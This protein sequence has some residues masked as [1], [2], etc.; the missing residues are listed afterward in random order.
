M[1]LSAAGLKE[2]ITAQP[3]SGERGFIA[4]LDGPGLGIAVDEAR[5]AA[6]RVG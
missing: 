2:D 1:T 6:H 5:I 4:P 3:V